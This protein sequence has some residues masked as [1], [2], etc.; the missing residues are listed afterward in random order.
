MIVVVF[1]IVKLNSTPAKYLRYLTYLIYTRSL[2]CTS[3][4]DAK[5]QLTNSS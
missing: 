2:G 3:R 5:I 4:E 1:A